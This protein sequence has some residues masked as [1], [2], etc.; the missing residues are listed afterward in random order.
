MKKVV[1]SNLIFCSE[2]GLTATLGIV[3]DKQCY[4]H[5]LGRN[6]R[7]LR[8]YHLFP[9]R[10]HVFASVHFKLYSAGSA[11]EESGSAARTI[12]D[13]RFDGGV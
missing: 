3:S 9:S 6:N 10:I 12:M 5:R 1:L 11:G 2:L 13:I 8:S 7:K 4:C